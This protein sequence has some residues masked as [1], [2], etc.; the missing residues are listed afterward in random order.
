MRVNHYDVLQLNPTGKSGVGAPYTPDEISVAYR[1]RS[2]IL[3]PDK[4]KSPSA[5][6]DFDALKKSYDVLFDPESRALFDA[7]LLANPQLASDEQVFIQLAGDDEVG[8]SP[9]FVSSDLLSDSTAIVVRKLTGVS[10]SQLIENAGYSSDAIL[11]LSKR[12]LSFAKAVLDSSIFLRLSGSEQFQLLFLIADAARADSS[13]SLNSSQR[14]AM[15]FM[16]GCLNSEN[17]SYAVQAPEFVSAC[18]KE[19][20]LA[21]GFFELHPDILF[22]LNKQELMAL[23]QSF[24]V[25]VIPLV[26]KY[27]NSLAVNELHFLLKKYPGQHDAIIAIYNSAVGSEKAE[28][29]R[30]GFAFIQL[31]QSGAVGDGGAAYTEI[32]KSL[33]VE[34]FKLA[35]IALQGM[36]PG[37]DQ[38]SL[39][40]DLTRR[41]LDVLLQGGAEDFSRIFSDHDRKKLLEKLVFCLEGSKKVVACRA[42]LIS[43]RPVVSLLLEKA[44]YETF[45]SFARSLKLSA[46]PDDGPREFYTH[47]LLRHKASESDEARP[48]L[49]K[50]LSDNLQAADRLLKKNPDLLI[51]ILRDDYYRA[52]SILNVQ[53]CKNL[54]VLVAKSGA[55]LPS[56]VSLGVFPPEFQAAYLAHEDFYRYIDKEGGIACEKPN[57]LTVEAF[58]ALETKAG[59]FPDQFLINTENP[60]IKFLVLKSV[61]KQLN[62]C[63][64]WSSAQ[65]RALKKMLF[66]VLMNGTAGQLSELLFLYK[67]RHDHFILEIINDS[68]NTYDGLPLLARLAGNKF[69]VDNYLTGS[70]LNTWLVFINKPESKKS[71]F[72]SAD[73]LRIPVEDWTGTLEF[74]SEDL[75]KI[76]RRDQKGID[77]TCSNY[78]GEFKRLAAKHPESALAGYLA[79][80]QPGVF[81]EKIAAYQELISSLERMKSEPAELVNT[82]EN[83]EALL[84]LIDRAGMD[85]ATINEMVGQLSEQLLSAL[86]TRLINDERHHFSDALSQEI[87]K[88]SASSSQLANLATIFYSVAVIYINKYR[89]SIPGN[90]LSA[91]VSAHGDRILALVRRYGLDAQLVNS[92]RMGKVATQIET[93]SVSFERKA[94]TQEAVFAT[95]KAKFEK[96][97]TGLSGVSVEKESVAEFHAE[98]AAATGRY[99]V[100]APEFKALLEGYDSESDD[101]LILWILKLAFKGD[102]SYQ[103]KIIHLLNDADLALSG[104]TASCLVNYIKSEIV[105]FE[106]VEGLFNPAAV[107]Q[108]IVCCLGNALGEGRLGSNNIEYL[109]GLLRAKKLSLK[110]LCELNT[111]HL[112]KLLLL[113][114]YLKNDLFT[115]EL[116]LDAYPL[117]LAPEQAKLFFLLNQNFLTV[118]D[119]EVVSRDPI[120]Q[121]VYSDL[122][123]SENFPQG[124]KVNAIKAFFATPYFEFIKSKLLAAMDRE[125][126][127]LRLDGGE[128]KASM[129]ELRKNR[130]IKIITEKVFAIENRAS[131]VIQTK[132]IQ[133]SLLAEINSIVK[134]P[135]FSAQRHSVKAFFKGLLGVALTAPLLCIPLAFSACRMSFFSSKAEKTFTELGASLQRA[136]RRA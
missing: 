21:C 12:N 90:V 116:S 30:K 49:T 127:R 45:K 83:L 134:E 14:K 136:F 11:A 65:L 35:E 60:D 39:S 8:A 101:P 38:K 77:R 29:L 15:D 5:T 120:K 48:F 91:I 96:L 2:R 3:H 133:D 37:V 121:A 73:N 1:A 82:D 104:R 42:L 40:L 129:I 56:G 130:I 115:Q 6:E 23:S 122:C 19:K 33:G 92:I 31:I 124:D 67:G 26:E 43:N 72:S 114:N 10:L 131:I 89:K 86:A 118:Q 55:L 117:S 52:E 123:F 74:L 68:I 128:E 18:F 99:K 34:A 66:E 125:M 126:S 64:T 135:T 9:S 28:L 44:N 132:A 47:F 4:N 88:Q 57:Q 53:F 85:V 109:V 87:Q 97:I 7:A 79:L 20:T 110:T 102:D 25:V 119:L 76:N 95:I 80:T 32:I 50:L 13:F 84:V 93:A 108:I 63:S 71:L 98:L 51:A 46:I 94:V 111:E 75:R 27:A 61:A 100:D 58:S 81:Q 16:L 22:K 113:E 24:Y 103:S 17:P 69:A 62:A 70:L 105:S 112:L 41:I 59:F 106:R 36:G 54:S 78:L 107:K